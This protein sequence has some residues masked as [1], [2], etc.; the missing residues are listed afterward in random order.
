MSRKLS[1]D[2]IQK[3]I[4]NLPLSQVLHLLDEYSKNT[5]TDVS[6]I[7]RTII[8][9]DKTYARILFVVGL[10]HKNYQSNLD[11]ANKLNSLFNEHYQGL[12]R[13]VLKKE[14]QNVNGIYN[15]DLSNNS[16]LIELGGVDN[17]INEVLNTINAISDIL[18]KYIKEYN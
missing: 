10:E 8:I 15:Q 1:L 7:K 9:N 12:S 18:E 13:G 17:N 4:N 16:I 2:E 6:R 5:H 3:A 14:G 11:L